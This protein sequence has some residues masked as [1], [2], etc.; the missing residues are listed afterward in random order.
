MFKIV[1]ICV[2]IVPGGLTKAVLADSS[3]GIV[4][5]DTN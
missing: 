1:W 4:L 5:H 2:F 3:I